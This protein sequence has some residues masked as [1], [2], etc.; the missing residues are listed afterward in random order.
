MSSDPWFRGLELFRNRQF[1]EAHEAWEELWQ[2]SDK[3]SPQGLVVRG[4]IQAAAACLKSLQ[5]NPRGLAI[6]KQRSAA[7]LAASGLACYREIDIQKLIQDLNDLQ[8][9]QVTA[10]AGLPREVPNL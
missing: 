4:L 3:A 1:W 6:L 8:L 9:G 10:L 7:T 2:A 5:G